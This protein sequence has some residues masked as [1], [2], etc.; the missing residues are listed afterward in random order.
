MD[1]E[2]LRQVRDALCRAEI[3]CGDF[4]LIMDVV[5]PGMFVYLDPPYYPLSETACFTSYTADSFGLEDQRR[6]A[7]VFHELDRR[8]CLVMLSNSDTS[9]IRELYQGYDIKVVTAKRLI[10]CRT[11]KRRPVCELVIRNYT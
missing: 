11:D 1:P 9:L 3:R 10:N 4:F 2:N 7:A 8:G 6:L 5:Q